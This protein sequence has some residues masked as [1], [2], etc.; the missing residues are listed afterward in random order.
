MKTAKACTVPI[1]SVFALA[2][3]AA[4]SAAVGATPTDLTITTEGD[5]AKALEQSF[6]L[7]ADGLIDVSN[8]RG[9][10]TVTGGGA[11]EVKLGGSLGAGS[12][13]VVEGDARRLQLRV[14]AEK[15]GWFNGHGPARDSSLVLSVPHGVSVKLDLV[16]ADGKIENI[17][18]K[19]IEID[20]VSGSVRVD[21]A[22]RSI[23]IDSV[24]GDV[25]LQVTRAGATERTH[26]QSVSGDIRANG[27]DGRVK[28]ETVSG[29][30]TFAAPTVA[31]FSAESVSGNVEAGF[32]PGK[33][34][35]VRAE[36][37]SGSLLLHLP[38]DLAARL[39]AETFSGSLKT[40]WGK[41]VKAEYGP[42]ST[43]DIDGSDSS[44]TRIDVQS[45]SG[46]VTLRKQ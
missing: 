12:K 31:E 2:L 24:S 17:D 46:N 8:V 21:G 18:G 29:T 25:T 9:S 19:S 16:S 44:G 4:A 10:V 39:H 45:F 43:L 42:G 22:A 38:A 23:E 7:A 34:A 40:D 26:L 15:S 27:A 28:L 35:R 11:N 5:A 1:R 14:E 3:C 32:A 20:N 41:V 6:A 36:T 33:G 30:L 13:L 37:M